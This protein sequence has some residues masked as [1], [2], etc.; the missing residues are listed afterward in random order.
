MTTSNALWIFIG[1][2]FIGAIT[3]TLAAI[4]NIIKVF[5][6]HTFKH[7]ALKVQLAFMIANVTFVIY[8]L[9]ISIENDASVTFWNSAPT[10]MGNIIPFIL[11][12]ILVVG[13][14]VEDKRLH[15]RKEIK[16]EMSK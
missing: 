7:I 10:W 3:L 1:I 14:I 11:N 13:K 6:E 15:S 2:G 9:G 16:Q 5:K 4:F 12:A 8:A